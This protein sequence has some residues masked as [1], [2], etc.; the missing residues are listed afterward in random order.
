MEPNYGRV[1]RSQKEEGRYAGKI[2]AKKQPRSGGLAWSKSDGTTAGGDFTSPMLHVEHKH[3]EPTTKSIGI[4][5]KWLAQV[6]EGAKRRLRV[7]AIGLTF[8]EPEGHDEDWI[9]LPLEFA[10]RLIR[11]LEEDE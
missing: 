10:M 8:K 11:T 3:A 9:A 2:G 4:R 1:K 6:T 7:P 5:R